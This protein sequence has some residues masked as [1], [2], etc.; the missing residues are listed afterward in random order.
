MSGGTVAG[1]S[2]SG[3]TTLQGNTGI[4]TFNINGSDATTARGGAGNDIFNINGVTT[5]NLE[6]EAGDDDFDF[7]GAVLTGSIMG[8]ANNDEILDGGDINLQNSTSTLIGGGNTFASIEVFTRGGTLTGPTGAQTWNLT[9]S[10]GTVAGV[11]F[12]GFTTL[13]GNTGIDTFNING[14][15]AT[16]IRGGSGADIFNINGTTTANLFGETGNDDFDFAGAVLTGN[17]DGGAGAN[18]E[19]LDGG[20]V[21]LGN[22]TSSLLGGGGTFTNVETFTNGGTLTGPAGAQTW[23]LTMS[24]GTVAGVSF[25]GFTTLTG[26][27]GVDTFNVGGNAGGATTINGGNGADVFNANAN[28]AGI[29]NGDAGMDDFNLLGRRCHNGQ[30][31]GR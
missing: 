28:F 27:T 3:F 22:R 31:R 5:L 29:F 6:G 21:H 11:S 14:S 13:Q 7:A 30:W 16:N 10:G 1:V 24:G 8:G 20:D 15:D 25:S 19:I 2:F 26:N 4:D 17:I 9:M 18:D 23:N 12:S